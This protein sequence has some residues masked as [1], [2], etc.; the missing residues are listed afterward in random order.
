MGPPTVLRALLA[1]VVGAAVCACGP[2]KPAHETG[3]NSEYAYRSAAELA[4]MRGT[5]TVAHMSAEFRN[6]TQPL[7]F[8][9][10]HRYLFAAT[11]SHRI[12]VIDTQG[13]RTE[14]VDCD[15]CAMVA[16]YSRDSVGWWAD[17]GGLAVVDLAES[18]PAP[19]P[20]RQVTLPPPET[21]QEATRL[22]AVHDDEFVI[23]R[24]TRGLSA[25]EALFVV[26]SG[27]GVVKPLGITAANTP[28]RA[29]AVNTAGTLFGYAAY[30]QENP[31]CGDAVVGI[32]DLRSGAAT[33]TA[34][35]KAEPGVRSNVARIWWSP[36]D[37]LNAVYTRWDCSTPALKQIDPPSV[38]RYSDHQWSEV[39][40]GPI[41][42]TLTLSNG[43]RVTI[44]P[45]AGLDDF[46]G[47]L[48]LDGPAGRRQ[49]ANDVYAIAMPPPS[50]VHGA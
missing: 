16:P 37:A 20:L 28:I 14:L 6:N 15:G 49:I 9:N 46:M 41:S 47:T 4:L 23:A 25:P 31:A 24:T 10:S 22:L 30:D 2:G 36:D 3:T 33:T 45:G 43:D 1:I 17:P 35:R 13:R 8:T 39:K 48:Y 5:T 21:P 12:A 38:W 18:N 32:V 19:H 34:P 42:Q 26:N 40:P 11:D 27:S 50:Q 44:I 29:A 7:Y